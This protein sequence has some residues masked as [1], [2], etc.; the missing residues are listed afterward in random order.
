LNGFVFTQS[1]SHKKKWEARN[2]QQTWL[3]QNSK[4]ETAFTVIVAQA[5]SMLIA[6]QVPD[7]LQR[8]KLWPAVVIT[9]TFLNNQ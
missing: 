4:A 2:T 7:F 9:A 1:F 3:F 6:V 5:K 8:F